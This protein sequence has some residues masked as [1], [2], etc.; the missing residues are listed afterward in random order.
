MSKRVLVWMDVM[1]RRMQVPMSPKDAA[2][3]RRGAVLRQSRKAACTR[4]AN[5]A[6]AAYKAGRGTAEA[7]I[8]AISARVS[9]CNSHERL[10]VM[11]I[12]LDGAPREI[13]W[14]VFCDYWSVCDAT[15]WLQV[16][17]LNILRMH[18]PAILPAD[19]QKVFDALPERVPVFRG[20]SRER[21]MG[22]S[23]TTE[24]R[25]AER[26]AHG[27]RGIRVPDPVIATGLIA[28]ADILVTNSNRK[29]HEVLLDPDRLQELEVEPV[30]SKLEPAA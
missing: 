2:W 9:F 15:W 24:R 14:S 5:A 26:F 17:L 18:A 22:L 3:M 8:A 25:V 1:G 30:G 21:T 28:K 19:E 23:W 20:C 4:K 6:L 11:L 7:A 29:E 16:P 12:R 10:G 27:H 13:F